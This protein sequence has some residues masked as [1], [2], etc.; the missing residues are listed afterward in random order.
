[1][2][3]GAF[4]ISTVPAETFNVKGSI[5]M[6]TAHNFKTLNACLALPVIAGLLLSGCGSDDEP[7]SSSPTTSTSSAASSAGSS[8]GSA[9][10]GVGF[11]DADVTFA[12]GMIPHHAQAVEMADLALTKASSAK[13]KDLA[14]KVKAAQAPEIQTLSGLLSSWNQPAPSTEGSDSMEGM[15]HGDAGHA[16]SMMTSEQMDDLE[17]ASGADFDRM[18]VDM[19]IKHH[20]GAV[21][22]GKT[23]VAD[24]T[25]AQATQLAQTVIDA[26]TTEIAEL[27]SLA[28]ELA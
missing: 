10:P 2:A 5:S 14:E 11:N 8:A 19:M 20:E 7:T 6:R 23:E 18:W 1:M 24:G 4:L 27:K 15:D 26:Q 13:V 28:T 16:D 17:A 12:S 3:A 9:E 21:A 22:M 25:D